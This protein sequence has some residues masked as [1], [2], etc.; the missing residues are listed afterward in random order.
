MSASPWTTMDVGDA[1]GVQWSGQR[2]A[3][4]QFSVVTTDSRSIEDGALF[5]ALVGD[6][7]DG[8]DFVSEAV[9][10]GACGV[11]LQMGPAAPLPVNVAVFV[12]PDTLVALGQ[13]AA[14]RRARL[15]SRVVGITGSVGKTTT[16]E[17]TRGALAAGLRTH[18]TE[19]NF[20]NRIGLPLTVLAAPAD[21][22]VMV[23]EMGTNEPGEIETLTAI[24]SP[25]IGVVTTV[26]EV[27]LEGLG[28]FEGV[29][30]EKLALVRGLPDTGVALVGDEPPVLADAARATGKDVR[31]AGVTDRAD[32]SLRATDCEV[33]ADGRFSFSWRGD[34]VTMGIPGRATVNAAALA[35]GV[36]DAC[37]VDPVMAAR[38][39]EG[40]RPASMR[41]EVRRLGDVVVVVDCY[42]ASP[43]SVV[44][45]CELLTELRPRGDRIAALGSM[46]ELGARSGALHR[47]TLDAVASLDIPRFY[48]VGAFAE[49]AKGLDA[50]RFRALP[51]VD[52]LGAVLASEVTTGDALLLKAS[53]GVRMEQV[54]PV[55]EAS[56]VEPEGEV[57]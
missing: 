56:L 28:S 42:N 39:L 50:G 23:L 13:L 9:A 43:Q 40:V 4:E 26:G 7:F 17:L 55:L 8:H 46:L 16:K 54:L 24:A 30:H 48:L 6:R 18:A 5:V 19:G 31:V 29:L 1:L 47:E 21:T 14:H 41:A 36:A 25:D 15:S 57:A 12:V 2:A 38:G 32:P 10:A 27:H 3:E 33:G 37:G 35:L 44:A 11:V 34:T 45:A 51:G 53:R 22:E 52:E 20:N 49:A